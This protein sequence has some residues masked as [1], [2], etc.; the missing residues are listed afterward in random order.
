MS[1]KA[2]KTIMKVLGGLVVLW[3]VAQ[4]VGMLPGGGGAAD[5]GGMA[6]FFEGIATDDLETIVFSGPML[7]EAL[8]LERNQTDWSVNGHPADSSFV[9]AFLRALAAAEVG[10]V[11]SSNPANHDRMGVSGD[12]A[13]T[14]VLEGG[15]EA[16]TLLLGGTGPGFGTV[17]A[18]LPSHDEVRLV[19]A[20]LRSPARRPL[21]QWRSKRMLALDTAEV[22]S[23]TI[24]RD[25][26][27]YELA[28]ADSGWAI[29]GEAAD[30]A[31]VVLMLR[32]FASLL[33]SGFNE[34]DATE[35][36]PDRVI[37]VRGSGADPM[38]TIRLWYPPEGSTGNLSAR[39][40]GRVTEAG[41]TYSVA[42]WRADRIAPERSRILPE[43]EEEG[44]G[45]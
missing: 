3:G 41:A 4:L 36:E 9:A 38:V 7:E 5:D 26:E 21:D 25:G 17:F 15:P 24:E 31:T 39:T 1:D 34:D 12:S 19:T 20:D 33:A 30:S 43:E 2:L 18:R 35:G 45:G 14:V 6:A 11:L 29:G 32:E 23:I 44:G 16:Q 27:S 10:D 8:T 40:E 42:S 22:M 28:R 37:V 13:T